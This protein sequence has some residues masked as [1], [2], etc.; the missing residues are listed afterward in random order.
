MHAFMGLDNILG[1]WKSSPNH[2]PIIPFSGPD[3]NESRYR[4]LRNVVPTIFR[5][6]FSFSVKEQ[7]HAPRK[8]YSIDV[9]LSNA[10]GFRSSEN[11]GRI[12]EN[13]VA[14]ELKRRLLENPLLEL[15]HWRDQYGKEV[16][17]VVKDGERVIQLVQVCWDLD[18]PETKKREIGSLLKA[19]RLFKL[20]Q[21]LVITEELDDEETVKGKKI[22]FRPLWKWLLETGPVHEGQLKKAKDI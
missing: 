9:G 7:E 20:K 14:I 17:F 16:D 13:V 15:Y 6:R 11:I 4:F 12:A 10:V 21:G 5:K 19:M 3:H 22:I 8:I 18:D 2:R 1:F